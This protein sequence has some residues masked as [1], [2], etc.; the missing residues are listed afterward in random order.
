VRLE[1]IEG[2][3]VGGELRTNL[4]ISKREM[5][6]PLSPALPPVGAGEIAMERDP[7][8]L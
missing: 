3:R 2:L 5:I 7:D 4:K 6:A 8:N 1:K